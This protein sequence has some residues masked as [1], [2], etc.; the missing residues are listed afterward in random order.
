MD[1]DARKQRILSAI[2]A[3][4]AAGGDPVGSNQL[5]SYLDMALSSATLRNEMAALTRLGLLEQPHTSAGRVP[6]TEGYRYYIEN[7]IGDSDQLSP[8]HRRRID[9]AFAGF[10]HDPER[11][12]KSAAKELSAMTGYTAVAST[13][14]SDDVKVAYFNVIQTGRYNAA[15]LSVSSVGSVATRVAATDRPFT[16]EDINAV[17][18][19]LNRTL[20]FVSKDDVNPLTENLLREG[21]GSSQHLWPVVLA[22]ITLLKGAGRGK[23]FIAG[24]D[25]LVDWPELEGSLR[26]CLKLLGN[27][28]QVQQLITPPTGRTMVVMG[29]ECE[30]ALPGVAVAAKRYIAGGGRAGAIAIVGPERMPYLKI[31]PQLEYFADKLGRAMTGIS[32]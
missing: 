16:A 18:T 22:A 32:E 20:C 26:G 14:K 23:V 9:E 12:A 5:C 21:L 29:A 28:D 7:L 1:M 17:T 2:V 13:P 15:V 25:K 31:L 3:L 4:Y 11:L 19:Y 10:D 8:A 30:P 6:S 27:T 24:Q